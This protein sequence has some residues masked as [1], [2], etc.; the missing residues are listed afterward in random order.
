MSGLDAI[1]D[2]NVFVSA[3][4]PQERGFAACRKLLDRLD[5]GEFRAVIST[6]TIAELRAGFVP[7]EVPTVWRPMLTHL[8]TS[9][10]Y[11][12]EPVGPEIAERAGELRASS[13]L[14]LPDSIIVATGQLVGV[15]ILV[16]Q[17]K[18]LGRQQHVLPVRSPFDLA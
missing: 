9:A 12:V 13:R 2:T 16:S 3:R 17:D 6:V 4:N 5:R 10:N 14:T 7:E 15:P 11:R 18:E 8:L 1:V